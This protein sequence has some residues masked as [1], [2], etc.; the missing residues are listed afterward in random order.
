MEKDFELPLTINI[1]NKGEKDSFI[2]FKENFV[3]ALNKG[4]TISFDVANSEEAIYYVAQANKNLIVSNLG[5]LNASAITGKYNTTSGEFVKGSSYNVIPTSFNAFVEDDETFQEIDYS[6]VG[7]IPF[8]TADTTLGLPEGNRF[9]IKLV[10]KNIT[11]RDDLPS[12]KICKITNT[13]DPTGYNEYTKSAFEE[14]GSLIT[15][16]NVKK[17]IP[18]EIIVDWYG[19]GFTTYTFDFTESK[20]LVSGE[21]TLESKPAVEIKLPA[22]IKITNIGKFTEEFFEHKENRMEFVEKGNSITLTVEKAEQA[23]Y[24]LAQASKNLKVELI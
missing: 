2:P 10:A 16:V 23:M 22:T 18:I 7:E 11:S 3:V 5:E 6:V 9:T 1:A 13:A 20:L 8:E 17:D 14:D 24:Y 12:G 15:V 19:E 4:E 21:E